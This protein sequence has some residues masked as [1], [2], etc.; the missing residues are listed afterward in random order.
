MKNIILYIGI[1]LMIIASCGDSDVYYSGKYVASLKVHYLRPSQIMFEANN[2]R[3]TTFQFVVNSMETPWEFQ[4]DADWY[5]FSTN[6]GDATSNVTLSCDENFQVGVQ[7]IGVFYLNSVDSDWKYSLPMTIAQAAQEPYASVSTSV[8]TFKGA[9]ATETVTVISNCEYCVSCSDSWVSI[10]KSEDSSKL[11]ISV[12]ENTSNTSRTSTIYL[13]Y[14]NSGTILSRIMVAQQVAN[15]TFGTRIL[16][17]ENSATDCII[18]VTSDAS[19]TAK[20]S[21][22][23]IYLSPES[24]LAGESYLKV[25]VS[26]NSSI[27]SRYG[28]IL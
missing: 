24:G 25:S 4:K 21:S 15:V 6:T 28:Y 17:L 20:T 5:R 13:T 8:V 2:S 22:T 11:N 19:W 18:K 7:R 16:E 27:S 10:Q 23:W 14:K 9:A 26:F 12:V 1:A 3:D